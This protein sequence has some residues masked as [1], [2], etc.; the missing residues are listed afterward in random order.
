MCARR[1]VENPS[2]KRNA[3]NRSISE[4]PVTMSAFSIGMFVIPI[5]SVRTAGRIAWIPSAAAVP[6]SDAIRA[7]MRAINSV[8][9]R[10]FI[11]SSFRKS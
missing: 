11:M 2:V 9:Y 3:I 10:A 4:M 6:I 7:D 8:V 1:M 5:N